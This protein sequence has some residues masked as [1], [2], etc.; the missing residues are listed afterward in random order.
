M[1]PGGKYVG[2]YGGCGNF[3]RTLNTNP[4]TCIPSTCT[5]WKLLPRTSLQERIKLILKSYPVFLQYYSYTYFIKIDC[6]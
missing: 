4:I 2:C 6:D 3:E 5:V 1:L